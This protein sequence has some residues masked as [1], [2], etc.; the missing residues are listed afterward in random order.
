MK[1]IQTSVFFLFINKENNIMDLLE[2]VKH[3]TRKS[4]KGNDLIDW[5][6]VMTLLDPKDWKTFTINA[7]R[8]KYRVAYGDKVKHP[9]FN[10]TQKGTPRSSEIHQDGVQISERVLLL[11]ETQEKDKDFILKAHGFDPSEFELVL[12]RNNLWTTQSVENGPL[13]NYQSRITVKP[14]TTDVL[15]REQIQDIVKEFKYVHDP[16]Q[17]I[18]QGTLRHKA[19]Q[20]NFCDLHLGLFSWAPETGENSDYKIIDGKVKEIVWKIK[21]KMLSDK[22]I[23]TLFLCFIGDIA[24]V[25][26][27]QGETTAGTPVHV[28]GRTKKM[29]QVLYKL[30][31]YIIVELSVV[32]RVYVKVVEGN[33]SRI[34]EFT[35][36]ES[37]QYIF[38][39]NEH[40]HIDNSPKSRKAFMYGNSLIG[41]MHGD[42]PKKQ[43][44]NWLQIEAREMWGKATYAEIHAGHWHKENT[45][46]DTFAG[47]TIRYNPTPKPTDHYEYSNGYI[48]AEKKVA[49]YVWDEEDG[50]EQ[51]EY[52]K[53]N[54][55]NE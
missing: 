37:M 3:S 40:I 47:I 4:S 51:I 45:E 49:C 50:L 35:V 36:F 34:L 31:M 44:W 12:V 5:D 55:I 13:Y 33:H 10:A 17:V 27:E 25:D 29:I 41:L 39:K 11:S 28:E 2:A 38:S 53:S 8:G 20:V 43:S 7:V 26:N 52:F 15:T 46:S 9:E 24:H 1:D 6:K 21:K 19:L 48:G 32:P 23:D 18:Q 14:R 30:I 42:M 22:D 54:F 16:I